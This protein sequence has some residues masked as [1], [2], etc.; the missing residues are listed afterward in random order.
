MFSH[1]LPTGQPGELAHI[2][3]GD[4]Q[5]GQYRVEQGKKS[6][7]ESAGQN[8]HPGLV[9]LQTADSVGDT[10]NQNQSCA[11]ILIDKYCPVNEKPGQK[12]GQ[13]K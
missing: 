13:V 7:A 6:E 11:E 8:Q 5:P 12:H 9:T 1:L 4:R 2:D 10:E 3:P